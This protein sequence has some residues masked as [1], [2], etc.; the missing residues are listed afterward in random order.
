M[1]EEEMSEEESKSQVSKGEVLEGYKKEDL[2]IKK[3]F[4]ENSLIKSNIESFNN[5]IENELQ[6]IIDE[7]RDVEPTI[8]PENME[9]FRIELGDI[10]VE[11]PKIVEADGSVRKIY[12]VEARMRKL[13]YTAPMKLEFSAYINGIQ[14]E[15]FTR[16]I[17]ELPIMLKSDHCH[18]QGLSREELIEKGEDPDDPGGYFIINGSEKT[19]IDMEDLAS[20]RFTVEKPSSGRSEYAGKV[21]SEKESYKI[22]HT[23]EKLKDG[24]FYL[25]FTRVQQVPIM[26]LLKALGLTKDEE[27]VNT[28]GLPDEYNS[29]V[30]INLYDYSDLKDS[31]EAVDKIAKHVGITQTKEVRIERAGEILDKYLLP[32][33]GSDPE[34]RVE[35]AET[36]CK[37]LKKFILVEKGDLSLDDKDHYMNKRLKL[38]GELLA[39]LLRVNVKAL[40][41]DMLYNFQRKVKRGKVPVIKKIIREKLLTQKIYGSMATGNWVAN[42]TGVSQR[43]ERLNFLHLLSHL[44]R[45]VSP[46]SSRQENF[47]ARALHST[48]LGRLCPSETPEGT[49]IGLRKY[50]ALLS[51]ISTNVDEENLM[52]ELKKAGLSTSEK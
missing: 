22:P 12:P 46:L 26:L 52:K 24:T 41:G 50:L 39:D 8:I 47:E 44:R 32:H 9:E 35:K 37:Y 28:V 38:P 5:F 2:L 49:N 31:D 16:T 30:I 33:V 7:N 18:L 25:T 43:I 17:G 15:N 6:K 42:R 21:F 40:I 3:Y 34:D 27:I 20:N 13:S 19:I 10:K 11:M 1:S 48:H 4:E 29:D 51:R 14:R 36:L 45:V 23:M